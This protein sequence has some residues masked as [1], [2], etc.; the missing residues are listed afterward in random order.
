MTDCLDRAETWALIEKD[1][2]DFKRIR[3]SLTEV[4]MAFPQREVWA[5]EMPE[6]NPNPCQA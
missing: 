2:P 3:R 6:Q 1:P 4:F 5:R